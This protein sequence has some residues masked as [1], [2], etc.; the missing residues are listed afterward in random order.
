MN[1]PMDIGRLRALVKLSG[2][3][4]LHTLGVAGFFLGARCLYVHGDLGDAAALAGGLVSGGTLIALQ[5][6]KSYV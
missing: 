6:A 4:T 3:V 2:L 5:L 1:K